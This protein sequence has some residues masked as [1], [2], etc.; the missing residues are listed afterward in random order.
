MPSGGTTRRFISLSRSARC[1][2]STTVGWTQA[3]F[4][5]CPTKRTVWAESGWQR[6]DMCAAD[7]SVDLLTLNSLPFHYRDV[8]IQRQLRD[9]LGRAARLRPAYFQPIEFRRRAD[10]E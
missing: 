10:P 2:I 8:S 1:S 6:R 7:S 5:P 4:T 3:A 9:P